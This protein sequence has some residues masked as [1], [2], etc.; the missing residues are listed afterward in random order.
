MGMPTGLCSTKYTPNAPAPNPNP[1]R[2]KLIS[3][4]KFK[5]AYVLKVLYLDATNFE[6]VKIM[7][8]EGEYQGTPTHLDPHFAEVGLS[9][10]ARFKPTQHGY[11]L[12]C[13]VAEGLSALAVSRG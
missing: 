1:E 4:K 8:Y 2:W 13:L 12:A 3:V 5:R 10:I 7:V 11:Q 6:G 9:P